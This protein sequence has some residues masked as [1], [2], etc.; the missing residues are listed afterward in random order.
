MDDDEDEDEDEDEDDDEDEGVKEWRRDSASAS[1][2]H[3]YDSEAQGV[4]IA[5]ICHVKKLLVHAA[6]VAFFGGG[7]GV[8]SVYSVYSVSSVS[9]VYTVYTVYSVYSVY[10][11]CS[12]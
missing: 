3:L 6:G 1:E 10:S 9:S 7:E 2:A 11:V 5:I 8:Y 12:V 4:S